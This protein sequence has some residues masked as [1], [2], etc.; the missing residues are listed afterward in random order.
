MH[1]TAVKKTTFVEKLT[2][3]IVNAIMISLEYE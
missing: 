3:D 1:D 2:N